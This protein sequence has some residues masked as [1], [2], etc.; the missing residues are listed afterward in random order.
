M[1]YTEGNFRTFQS[2][3]FGTREVPSRPAYRKDTYRDW[4]YHILY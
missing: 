3:D 1:L 2:L 4:L